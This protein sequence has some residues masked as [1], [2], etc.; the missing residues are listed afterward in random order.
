MNT[1][2]S[3][4]PT[5][6]P[7]SPG[8]KPVLLVCDDEP[9]PRDSLQV[10][11]KGDFEVLLAEN[12]PAA[13]ELAQQRAVDVAVCDIRM[14]GMSGLEVL[15]R[16]KFVAPGI[17]V[18]MMT[19]YETTDTLRQALRLQAFDYI[20]KPFDVASV[21]KTV[22]AALQKRRRAAEAATGAE[23]DR[24][25]ALFAELQEHRVE[26]Q[27]ARARNE[28]YASIIH[29]INGPLTVISGFLQLLNQ[30]LANL[31]EPTAAD[32]E[33]IR[34]RL[35][36]ITRQT[37]N[38][39]EISRRYLS[40]LR[41][42][43]K[44]DGPRVPVNQLLADMQQLARVHPSAGRHPFEVRPLDRDIAVRMNGTD[45]IQILRNLVVNAFQAGSEPHLVEVTGTVF[46][47]PLDL[48]QFRD[49]ERERILN[50]ENFDNTPPL[51]ALTVRDEG[52]GI[53][54]DVLPRMFR[55]HFTTKAAQHGTGLG[56]SIIHRLVREARGALRVQTEPG[57]GSRFTLYLPAV[58]RG[59]Q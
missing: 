18:V 55:T 12:G 17:E 33:F 40:F 56:L 54:P 36:T 20:N 22:A 6:P 39:I 21:R 57:R 5:A 9:G 26:E 37:G 1:E 42:S 52:P 44:D 47:A 28:I 34:D 35:K 2:T 50:L 59:G 25:N 14:A 53:P 15:E 43:E 29:D 30:R 27:I 13:I 10:I 51:V 38:C 45:L 58:A 16:L 11:F 8:A 46:D 3:P 48:S 23:A 4:S 19:A 24:I 31:T 41:R 49:G 7:P 32:V